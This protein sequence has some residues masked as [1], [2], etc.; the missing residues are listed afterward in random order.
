MDLIKYFKEEIKRVST[1]NKNKSN[2][3]GEVFTP[4]FLIKEMLSS[5]PEDAFTDPTKSFL[6]P[7]C[8]KGNFPVFIIQGLMKGLQSHFPKEKQRYKHII[9][10]MIYMCEYQKESAIFVNNLFS[11]DGEFKVNLYVGDTL[12]MP[13]D[14]F[15]LSYEERKI[16][17]PDN[18]IF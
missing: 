6:D 8:G 4:S 17:Y 5:L 2:Q 18:C 1:Y 14:F 15:D 16:K 7:C 13:E 9:E 10:N 3:H 12:Q 11:L